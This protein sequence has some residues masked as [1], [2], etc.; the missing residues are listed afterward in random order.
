MRW[1][2][3]LNVTLRGWFRSSQLDR[4]L[5][6]ELRFHF[7]SQVQANLEAGMTPAEARRSA[8]LMIGNPEPIREASRDGRAGAWTR[9]F[10]RDLAHGIRSLTKAPGFSVAAI[11][12]VALGVGASTAI[13]SVVYGVALQPLP[14]RE[15]DR[16]VHIWTV[17][18]LLPGV[19]RGTV[20]AADYREWLSQNR[21]FDDIA[22]QRNGANFNL[23]GAGEPERLLG[24]RISANLF[25]LLGVAPAIGRGF[26]P[27]ENEIG[28]DDRVLLSDGL[29]RRRFGAD[30]SIVG[31]TINLSGVPHTVVGVMSRAF[32]YPTRDVQ[33]WVPLTINPAEL[34]RKAPGSSLLTVARLKAGVT[35]D[36]AQADMDTIVA[37]LASTFE[38]NR[39][40]GV[41][42]SKI[43]DDL[44]ANVDT[45][46][47]VMLAA[48]FCLLIVAALNLSTLLSVR[49]AA[50][51]R[52]LAVRVA[53]GASRGRVALQAV[54]ETMP[55]LAL[56]GGLGVAL[57]AAAIAVFAPLAPVGMPRVENITVNATV[58]TMAIV[59]LTVTGLVAVM[60]PTVQAWRADLTAAFREDART[61]TGSAR[62]ARARQALV[63]TQIALAVPLLAGGM[64]LARTFNTLTSIDPGFQPEKA[65]TLHLAIPRSKYPSDAR[66]AA[67]VG[68]FAER[69]ATVP[70][71]T[72]AG[73][74]NRLPLAGGAQ[75]QSM[76]FDAP[77]PRQAALPAVDAR[78]VT[79][80][81]FRA[82][83]IPLLEGRTFD[84]RDTA[85]AVP[86]AIVDERIGRLM[87]PG[88]SAIGKRLRI[89]AALVDG[90]PQPWSEIV[91]VVGHV[92]HDALDQDR[93][94][95]LYWN[96]EQRAMDRMVLVVRTAG[97]PKPLGA[98]VIRAVHD[99]DAEQPVYDVRPMTEVVERS[100]GQRWMNMVLVGGFAGVA[101][102][103]SA[104][105]V[106]GV[107]AFGVAQQRREFG[108][109]LALGASRR[110]IAGA[111][112]NRGLTLAAI[113]AMAGLAMALALTRAMGAMLYGVRATDPT[114]FGTATIVILIVA[115][116]ASYL[117]ARRAASVDPAVALRAE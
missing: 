61:S 4:E 16:L 89:P 88:V 11:A 1:H 38:S 76:E 19:G 45:A 72:A 57:A 103:L 13:F 117:P 24:S 102:L 59:L 73:L 107:I 78:S 113:G 77:E 44:V 81:Y 95:Q 71:V 27:D 65:L 60:L 35:L 85:G 43:H 14:F 98:S 7:D 46:L 22:A 28:N 31:R 63:V 96:Y 30:P 15:P 116:L 87:W 26:S 32:V 17:P 41:E 106:Y 49:A 112:V 83:G 91:G 39:D 64:L 84:A 53:L 90:S 50:R 29:W 108:I 56:G 70:G 18:T 2:H 111:V 110:G 10:G 62:Q 37:R 69:A 33:I 82:I 20:N 79:P 8:A 47:Y 58:V 52:E 54:A 74:V 86:V 67:V 34:A 25:P 97:E 3:R 75:F 94:P 109:R 36:Q 42:I 101:V 105:G 40:T 55:L 93:R 115:V 48:V 114:S 99:I 68:Q 23:V 51:G 5:D 6:E 21:V 9:Q 92:R 12:I 104:I 66:I 100:L 80:D